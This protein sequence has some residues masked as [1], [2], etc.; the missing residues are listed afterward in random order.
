[1]QRLRR[2]LDNNEATYDRELW[3][4]I[5]EQGWLGACIREEHGGLGLSHLE[6]CVLSE[7]LGRV[8]APIPFASTV[9]LFAEALMLAGSEDQKLS[10]LP[11]IARGD[12]I[13][14]VAGDDWIGSIIPLAQNRRTSFDN[15]GVTAQ[16]CRLNGIKSAVI[17]GGIADAGIVLAREQDLLSLFIVNLNAKGVARKKVRTLDP[18]RDCA[19]WQFGEVL[20][21]RLGRP[22]QGSKILETV[23]DKAAVLIAFEQLGGADR[24]LEMAGLY[25]ADRYAFG[26]PIGSFQAIKHKLV[27]VFVKNELARANCYFGAWALNTNAIQLPIAASAARV[28]ASD[29]FWH[30]SKENIQT[31]GGIGYTWESDC[32]LFYR[33][34]CLL[35]TAIASP[36][37]WKERLV[38]HLEYQAEE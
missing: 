17:D 34:A 21:E 20:A 37:I 12:L 27:D 16:D 1:M 31:H 38:S 13:G 25:A 7:E 18:T 33:R 14:A 10:Y 3:K 22:G 6:L 36:E 19:Q 15:V 8:L 28:A 32:H 24:C 4:S 30:A 5:A 11:R 26:K 29:A 9:Y 2:I 35:S 23:F